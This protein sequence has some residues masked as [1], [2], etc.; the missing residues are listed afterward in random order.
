LE[1]VENLVDEELAFAQ[2]AYSFVIDFFLEYG[3][4][5]KGK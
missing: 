3:F 1:E 4:Q 5:V 2:Q